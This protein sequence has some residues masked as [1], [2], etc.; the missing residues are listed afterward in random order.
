[1]R[2]EDLKSA[3]TEDRITHLIQLF[4]V[5]ASQHEHA[6]R[7]QRHGRRVLAA[8]QLAQHAIQWLVPQRLVVTEFLGQ[9]LQTMHI[10]EID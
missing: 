2:R 8:E 9:F 6:E 1:M 5:P 4:W 10:L 7:T 3:I